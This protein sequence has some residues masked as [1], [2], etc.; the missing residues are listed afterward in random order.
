MIKLFR[1]KGIEDAFN[2]VLGNV[3]KSINNLS[4]Q[5]ILKGDLEQMAENILKKHQINE[6]EIDLE[7]R[8]VKTTMNEILGSW[9]PLGTDVRRDQY[10]SC[11]KVNYT[12]QIKSGNIELLSVHPKTVSFNHQIDAEF[13]ENQFTIGY[14]TRYANSNLSEQVKQEVKQKMRLIIQS[15]RQV[16]DAINKEVRDFNSNLNIQIQGELEKKRE[17]LQRRKDQDDDL[18]KL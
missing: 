11:A 7:K 2:V 13:N 8:D 1:E 6:L 15:S 18:N 3:Q 5:E 16:I 12:F 17:E 4:N 14:Q 9:F 10:Y